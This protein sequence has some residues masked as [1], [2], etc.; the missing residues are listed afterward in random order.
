M[1][2]VLSTPQ[3]AEG[4]GR[5]PMIP[6]AI[7]E[8]FC[9][10]VRV[11]LRSV[12]RAPGV[13]LAVIALL[14]LG[15]GGLVS[16]FLPLRSIVLTPLPFPDSSRLV[17]VSSRVFDYTSASF[18]N[19]TSLDSIFGA[20]A[21]YRPKQATLSS[22]GAPVRVEMAAVTPGF[23]ATLAAAPHR[24]RDL[25]QSPSESLDTV[26]GYELWQTRLSGASDLSGCG[27]V[28]DGDRFRVVGVA[29]PGFDFPNGAQMWIPSQASVGEE[30]GDWT[31]VGRLRPGI[32][33]GQAFARL[34]V[35]ANA[36]TPSAETEPLQRLDTHLLGE[37]RSL[38]GMLWAVSAL[39]LL[40]ACAGVTN[41]LRARGLRRR[42]EMATR[43][44]VGASRGGLVRQSLTETSVL[45][46][47]G[48]S[49][50][51]GL[52]ALGVR[53]L[54][55][56]WPTIRGGPDG[57]LS[58]GSAV[59]MLAIVTAA[60]LLCGIVPALDATRTSGR[61]V[62]CTTARTITERPRLWVSVPEVL[63][64]A[65]LALAVVLLVCAALLLRSLTEKLRVP[66]G[67]DPR[68]VIVL[69]AYI[70]PSTELLSA[71]RQTPRVYDSNDPDVDR[72]LRGPTARRAERNRAWY[73]AA[74]DS[75]AA[76]PGVASV[77]NIIPAPF[78]KRQY[79][80]VAVFQIDPKSRQKVAKGTP[81][82][83]RLASADTFRV[84]GV[85][86]LAGRTFSPQEVLAPRMLRSIFG[87]SDRVDD[88]AVVNLT[89]AR[90]FWPNE[91]PIG[92]E[93]HFL[94]RRT[95]VGVV[96]DIH[97]SSEHLDVQPTV[98]FPFVSMGLDWTFLVKLHPGTP[99][100]PPAAAISAR[101][102]ELIPG[103]PPPR[104]VLLSDLIAEPLRG[105]RVG[106]VLLA[107]FA[108]LGATVA[109][110]GVYATASE[111]AARR[112]REWGVRIALGATARDVRRLAVGRG[113]RVAIVA[114]PVGVFGS[115]GVARGLSHWLFPIG[116]FDLLS[117]LACATILFVVA[118]AATLRPAIRA[119]AV[120]PAAVLRY[121]G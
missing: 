93:F 37:R 64:G 61:A 63:T 57:L 81:T 107:C 115:W 76:T 56:T 100:A 101:L 15:S 7:V 10:D 72:I 27:I 114:L 6:F 119:A 8:G 47:A 19:R 66:L 41:L 51:F 116:A 112:T 83:V 88:V 36:G 106:F 120:D 49:V 80:L 79:A 33:L 109:G 35:L 84:L 42:Q 34:K 9:R 26:V 117:A 113:L 97:E 95:V 77:G 53:L 74:I 16:V 14:A 1:L 28:L 59:L 46:F 50:G 52:S 20:I 31:V 96:A 108:A 118:L 71:R 92:R 25:A 62:L 102:Q 82:L 45:A 87:Q 104:V 48:A 12:A 43:L 65:Q 68:G 94:V 105:L 89:F 69:R 17:V 73:A 60:T 111:V 58:A 110:L 4:N 55:V 121:D 85:P 5:F 22:G 21:A 90:R 23:F 24:G 40:L 86:L 75:I 2:S 18:P 70:P 39:F 32:T 67:F 44:A 99:V 78:E 91:S 11:A 3:R 54:N 13:A 98:Y 30:A 38:L 103:L 29:Q